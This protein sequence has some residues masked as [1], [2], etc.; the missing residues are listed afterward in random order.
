MM[1]TETQTSEILPENQQAA[2]TWGAGGQAYDRISRQIADAIEHAVDRLDPRAGERILDAG[3]GTGWTARRV[4]ARGARVTGIDIGAGVIEA[5]AKLD[6]TGAIDFRV[7]DTE[8]LHFPDGHF[9]GVIS[10]FGVMFTGNPE[11]AARELA[12]V[13]RPGGRLALTTWAP[14]GRVFEM[15][16]L[17]Q[18]HA[19]KPKVP[20]PSPFA[21][22]HT[23]RLVE[24][25]GEA[26]DLGFEEGTSFYR[27]PSG[28]AAWESFSKGFGPVV[29]LLEK[30][31]AEDA[32]RLRTE[33]EIFHERFRTGAGILV[34]REYLI[35]VGKRRA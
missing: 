15:F 24:L 25:F 4:A 26:F 13:V 23:A 14:D 17:I 19:P 16:T 9:D 3:T 31:D 2:R 33:F 11:R 1:T 7:A 32:A 12:R 28:A 30:L 5:A 8:A 20:R 18:R 22:G 35:T 29:T 27:E 10:T 21:W 6:P 34:P